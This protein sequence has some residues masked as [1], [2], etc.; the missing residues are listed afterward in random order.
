[1]SFI[2]ASAIGSVAGALV[3]VPYLA[4]VLLTIWYG[5]QGYLVDLGARVFIVEGTPSVH[6]PPVIHGSVIALMPIWG[7][8]LARISASRPA[9]WKT[10][11]LLWLATIIALSI[12]IALDRLSDWRISYMTPV[13]GYL[14]FGA[15]FGAAFKMNTCRLVSLALLSVVTFV[16]ASSIVSWLPLGDLFAW[17]TGLSPSSFEIPSTSYLVALFAANQ[18][19]IW[20]F[21]GAF[22]G[23][24]VWS[25]KPGERPNRPIKR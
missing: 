17:C 5:R 9:W 15:L 12:G 14:G 19:F 6:M 25:L 3:A 11:P 4:V 10:A 2:K 18:W 7:L 16:A 23:L 22:L 1:M 21:H 13:L 8:L 20:V 24:A